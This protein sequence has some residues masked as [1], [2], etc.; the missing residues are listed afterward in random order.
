MP[1]VNLLYGLLS[2]QISLN[3]YVFDAYLRMRQSEKLNIT[4]HPVE[5]GAS[6]ADHC[7]K[8]PI[9]FEFEIGMSD[10]TFGKFYRQFGETKRSLK[11]YEV[12][13]RLQ[14]S[15]GFL[16]LVGKYGTYKNILISSI[17]PTDDNTTKEALRVRVQ[18]EQVITTQSKRFATN[19]DPAILDSFNRARQKAQEVSTSNE[20]VAYQMLGPVIPG[21]G[22]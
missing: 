18:L 16:T 12:L 4:K 6:I 2:N 1:V 9:E 20:S 17:E 19:T 3:G 22:K 8:S 13:T 10:C 11:A 14:E 5:T 15:G 21:S 7:Y